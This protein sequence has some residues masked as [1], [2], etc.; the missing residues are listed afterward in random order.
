MNKP[1]T[2]WSPIVKRLIDAG[3]ISPL[4]THFE[5][6][7]SVNEPI[8]A[9]STTY[10]TEEQFREIS[11]ALMADASDAKQI[12]HRIVVKTHS[13]PDTLTIDLP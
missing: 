12:A 8:R 11:A 6:T 7:V 5:L 4:A 2:A 3:I 13:L 10:V 1:T 9:I